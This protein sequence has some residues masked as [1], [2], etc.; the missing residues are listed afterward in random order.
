MSAFG[1]SLIAFTIL[2]ISF[3]NKFLVNKTHHYRVF[4]VV[5]LLFKTIIYFLSFVSIGIAN[6]GDSINYF[7]LALFGSTI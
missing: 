3:H 6:F 1:L 7:Y 4:L 2:S 5:I